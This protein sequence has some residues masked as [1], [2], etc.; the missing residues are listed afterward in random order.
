MNKPISDNINEL[1][2]R[3]TLY[4]PANT[5][6]TIEK[7]M[8]DAPMPMRHYHYH[9]YYELYYLF[10]GERYYF[11]KDNSYHIKPGTF[12]LINKYDIHC[13]AASEGTG[14]GRFLINFDEEFLNDVLIAMNETKLLDCFK[15]D[16]QII[17]LDEKSRQYAQSLLETILTEYEAKETSYVKALLLQLLLFISRHKSLTEDIVPDYINSSHRIISEIIGYI[18]NNYA[19]DITLTDLS[20]KHYISPYHL[21]RTFKKISGLSFVEYLNNVR[22]KEAQKLLKKT[23]LTIGQIGE[24]VGYKSNTHFT[25]A[26]KKITD[27]SPLS[28]RKTGIS[29]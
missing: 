9:D 16:V 4:V 19:E 12:V 25:R 29:D 1:R 26:F 22:I 24:A 6:F 2:H 15:K 18:N 7:I 20:E 23:D 28:Y 8:T 21:S 3:R 11:I 17:E 13:T 14:Y 27:I 5:P 10:G